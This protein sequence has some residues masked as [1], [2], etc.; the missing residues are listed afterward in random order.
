[1]SRSLLA[2]SGL[3]KQDGPEA[4][5]DAPRSLVAALSFRVGLCLLAVFRAAGLRLKVTKT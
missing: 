3:I 5:Q 4:A 1:M 2:H